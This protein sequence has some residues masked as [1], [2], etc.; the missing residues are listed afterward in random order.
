[1]GTLYRQVYGNYGMLPSRT[2]S[3]IRRFGRP[4]SADFAQIEMLFPSRAYSA[5]TGML[6][7]GAIF[8]VLAPRRIRISGAGVREGYLMRHLAREKG[9][10]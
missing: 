1:M 9:E 6:A 3:L 7:Y 10:L 5:V 4:S 2:A 8:Q